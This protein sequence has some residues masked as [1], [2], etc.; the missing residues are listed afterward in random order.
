MNRVRSEAIV[1]E[2]PQVVGAPESAEF[3]RIG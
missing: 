3:E 2:E 1:L